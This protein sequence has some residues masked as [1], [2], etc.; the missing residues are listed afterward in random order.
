[1]RDS[2]KSFSGRQPRILVATPEITYLP[3]GM[4]NMADRLRAKAGGMADVSA[5]LVA[6][7]FDM[8]ADVHVALPHYR[9]MFH[10]DV[11]NLISEELRLYKSKLPE[12]RIHLAEDRVFYYRDT[13]YS[14]QDA[15]LKVA[16]A[17]QREI[18]NNIVPTVKPDIIHCNDWMTGL[19]TA[20]GRRLGIPCLL[21]VHNIHTCHATLAAIEDRGI[22]AAEFWRFLY[23]S[24]MP[25]SYEETRESNPVDLLTSGIFAA[26]FINTVSPSFLR[27]I[28]EGRHNMVPPQ[29]RHEIAQKF[30]AG[31]ALGILNAPDSSYDPQ[32]D[33]ALIE[34]YSAASRH[35]AKARNK[36][37]LQKRLGLT[38]NEHAPLFLWPSRLD[39]VQKGCQLLGD[40]LPA[41][42]SAADRNSPQVVVV[43]SG[44]YRQRL[45]EI[46]S[47][48]GLGKKVA[49]RDFDESLQRLGYAAADFVLMPSSFEPCGLPQM[50]GCIYGALPVAH[51]TGGL[52]DTIEPMSVE[53]HTGNGFLFNVFDANGLL[54]A[55]NEA[56]R[57]HSLPP[58]VRAREISRV[59]KDSARRF[60]HSATA[61]QYIELYE[62]MLLRPLL[63]AF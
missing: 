5:A 48:A 28:I 37:A 46:V 62:K 34:R 15:D 41:V 3:H 33:R 13:V 6:A 18:I 51:D 44:A 35:A 1:M 43:A 16:L 55:M 36:A 17:F 21:T 11:A 8:G 19:I 63:R 47:S 45:V 50:I 4:G 60:T 58:D 29:V 24:R 2:V 40:V 10:V 12:S 25:S 23:F 56:L 42:V 20:M 30:H 54:W 57:F 26:H 38:V 49:I 59:M 61:R 7:L 27:E 14:G 52:H 39:P 22:D 9:R 32:S 53:R 31:C